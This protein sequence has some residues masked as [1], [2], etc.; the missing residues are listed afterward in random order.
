MAAAVLAVRNSR[1][2]RKTC[3][4]ELEDQNITRKLPEKEYRKIDMVLST[5]LVGY[6]LE[7]SFMKRPKLIFVSIEESGNE[8]ESLLPM[9][10]F[11]FL[12]KM[13]KS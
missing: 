4:P 12:K 8:E 10:K 5:L 6:V 3:A 2:T 9:M 7:F 1:C 13:R 11:C